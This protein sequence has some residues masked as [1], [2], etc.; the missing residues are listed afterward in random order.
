MSQRTDTAPATDAAEPP[1]AATTFHAIGTTNRIHVTDTATLLP[2]TTIAREHLAELDAAASRFRP[3]SEVSDVARLAAHKSVRTPV[4]PLLAD[5]LRAA[6]RGARIT[7]GLVDFTV[8]AALVAAGYDLDLDVVRGRTE[9]FRLSADALS[10]AGQS[11]VP[12]WQAVTLDGLDVLTCPAGTLIDLG[13]TAKAHAAD[14]I[15]RRLHAAL[16]GGFLVN[17]GGD[18]ASSGTLPPGGWRIGVEAADGRVRQVVALTGQAIATSSTQLR[19][20]QT[21]AGPAHHIIDPRT[22]RPAEAVWAQVTCVAADALEANA[23]TTAAVVLGA[24]APAWLSDN[25]IPARLDHRDGTVATTP[26]WP[27]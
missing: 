2:A 16:P 7:D 23:A 22:G 1:P 4:S 21:E 24:D 9:P 12:G 3:D 5:Y 14:V 6:I 13:A 17:L 20:W 25:G 15:A 10:R 18:I 27:A 11:S 26:G 8:G 19:T